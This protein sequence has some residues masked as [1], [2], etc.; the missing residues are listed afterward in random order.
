MADDGITVIVGGESAGKAAKNAKSKAGKAQEAD[1]KVKG[2]SKKEEPLEKKIDRIEKTLTKGMKDILKALNGKKKDESKKLK[3]AAS[4]ILENISSA[5]GIDEEEAGDESEKEDAFEK[6][7]KLTKLKPQDINIVDKQWILGSLLIN[8][9]LTDILDFLKKNISSKASKGKSEGSNESS[10]KTQI[11]GDTI[12]LGDFMVALE[13]F[14]YVA[15]RMLVDSSKQ[16]KKVSWA[17]LIIAAEVIPFFFEKTEDTFQ[18]IYENADKY[19]DI[20]KAANNIKNAYINLALAGLIATLGIPAY[21]TGAVGALAAIPFVAATKLLYKFVPSPADSLKSTLSALLMVPFFA[22]M[23]VN[24]KLASSLAKISIKDTLMG[25]ANIGIVAAAGAIVFAILGI[26]VVA[27]LIALGAV[28]ALAMTIGIFAFTLITPKVAEIGA[29]NYKDV[30]TGTLNMGIVAVSSAIIF[31]L[32]GLASPLIA[33]GTISAIMLTVGITVMYAAMKMAIKAGK[34]SEEAIHA[35]GFLDK[36]VLNGDDPAGKN[37]STGLFGFLSKFGSFKIIKLLLL[38]I[39]PAGLLALVG[40]LLTVGGFLINSG[41]KQ[42]AKIGTDYFPD[43]NFAKSKPVLGILGLLTFV[44]I[45]DN[46]LPGTDGKGK[47]DYGTVLSLIPLVLFGVVLK[48][49]ADQIKKGLD[50]FSEIKINDKAYST[51]DDLKTFIDNLSTKLLG[52]PDSKGNG[53]IAALGS[54]FGPLMKAGDYLLQMIPLLTLGLYGAILAAVAKPLNEG[55]DAMLSF[56]DKDAQ[57]SKL[58]DDGG[59]FDKIVKLMTKMSVFTKDIAT[60]GLKD[61]EGP[62]QAVKTVCESFAII[63]PPL[64]DLAK[65][66]AGLVNVG[67]SNSKLLIDDLFVKDDGFKGA[68]N[69]IKNFGETDISAFNQVSDLIKAINPMATM[70][71]DMAKLDNSALDRGINAMINLIEAINKMTGGLANGEEGK[72]DKLLSI[73][74]NN[75]GANQIENSPLFKVLDILSNKDFANS[76]F[77]KNVQIMSSGLGSLSDAVVKFQS[78]DMSKFKAFAETIGNAAISS[79]VDQIGKLS[80]MDP[81][82]RLIANDLQ[83]IANSLKEISANSDGL[84]NL[85]HSFEKNMP[86]SD[87]ISKVTAQQ[88]VETQSA[89]WQKAMQDYMMNI[90]GIMAAWQANGMKVYMDTPNMPEAPITSVDMSTAQDMF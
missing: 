14:M 19:K 85:S 21:L 74:Q 79:G 73:W 81:K 8:S 2:V 65:V 33:L 5:V 44:D 52:K 39:L 66:N 22:A 77:E 15:P 43:N 75:S 61:L 42:F 16:L 89:A 53:I 27:P 51:I 60:W 32:L 62:T 46:G 84:A 54:V 11:S 30:L 71:I 28:T 23:W 47:V 56:A 29:Y 59:P 13:D 69:S 45:L 70:V 58:V 76:G 57:L 78:T 4:G 35:L 9:T 72:I 26:P 83:S 87:S 49:A 40:V 68:F 64:L 1:T 67:I 37:N 31:S 41:L 3:G 12:E 10:N 6:A 20:S 86:Q 90:Y 34:I 88:D 25:M 17:A 24:V 18:K 63:V 82:L 55:I 80:E 38:S 48:F 36:G 7:S 50:A